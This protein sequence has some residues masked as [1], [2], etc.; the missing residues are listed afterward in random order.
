M[1]PETRRKQIVSLL[2][3]AEKGLVTIPDLSVALGVSE[4]TIRRDLEYLENNDSLH[5]IPGGAIVVKTVIEQPYSERASHSTPEK[6]AIGKIAA[7]MIQDGQRIILDSGTTTRQIAYNLAEKKDLTVVTHNI[8]IAQELGQYPHIKTFLLG[9]LV[10]SRELCTVGYSVRQSLETFAVDLAFLGTAGFSP[11]KGI[12]DM[13]LSEVEIKQTIIR[14]THEVILVADSQ[15]YNTTA[16]L[17]V[18]PLGAVKKIITDDSLPEHDIQA[19]EK[20]GI[21]VIT[22]RRFKAMYGTGTQE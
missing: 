4:M 18:A 21:E 20:E 6:I 9:G 19:I 1:N 14:I 12:T 10:K 11:Q 8:P 22:P 3:Q 13:D 5:R 17:K 7:E 15:K 16:L 2:N